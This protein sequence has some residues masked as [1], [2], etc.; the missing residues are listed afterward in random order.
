MTHKY[1][2]EAEAGSDTEKGFGVAQ[3]EKGGAGRTGSL[4]LEN[5]SY[6]I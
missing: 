2:C 5:A 1:T 6:Y 4:G 3:G